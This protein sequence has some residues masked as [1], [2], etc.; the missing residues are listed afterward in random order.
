MSWVILMKKLSVYSMDSFVVPGHSAVTNVF[1]KL[2]QESK[3][4]SLSIEGRI[5]GTQSDGEYLEIESRCGRLDNQ[6]R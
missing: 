2:E 3:G 6:I 5:C 4:K 1:Q